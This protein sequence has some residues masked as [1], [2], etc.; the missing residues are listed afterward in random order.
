MP[1]SSLKIAGVTGTN[2]KT[3]TA[4]LL[5]HICD[6]AQMRCGLIGTVVYKVGDKVVP[7]TRTTP[8]S[9]DLQELLAEM[10]DAGCRTVA[11]EVSSHAL[12]QGRVRNVDFD[13]AVFTNLT[14]DHL[15]FHGSMDE[16]FRAKCL[17]FEGLR[18]QRFKQGTAVVNAEDRYGGLLVTKLQ[19]EG[20]PV[21][22]YGFGVRCDFR[23]SGVRSDFNGIQ[24]QLD[25][26]GR[27][28]LVRLPLIGSFNILNALAALGAAHVMGVDVRTAVLALA[29]VPP[30]PGRLEAVPAKRAFRVF[31]DYAH[32]DDALRSVLKT[33]R[34]LKPRRLITV[35]GCGGDRDRGKRPLMGSVAEQF[36]DWSVVTSDNPRSED[37][38]EIAAEVERGM[39]GGK[40][41]VILDR[42]EAIQKAVSL[43]GPR[44]IVLI[45]GKGHEAVQEFADRREAFDDVAMARSAIE[46]MPS[47]FGR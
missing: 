3:T 32:T 23:A 7:A 45:A 46:S 8:E 34:E 22:T 13:A 20:T 26:L 5:Q 21:L 11:M 38:R 47:E 28:W 33:L 43:A 27:S 10:R 39:R 4:F 36:S 30:V 6:V 41:E 15:D 2:G 31:V 37:P 25:A 17:L 16:Y 42:K 12:S 35:F 1:S 40:H 29:S 44:D 18:V 24:F 14:Q 19:Q 9:A